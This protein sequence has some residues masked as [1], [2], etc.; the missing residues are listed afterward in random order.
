MLCSRASQGRHPSP[1]AEGREL[2][3]DYD[4]EVKE[5]SLSPLAE[6]RELKWQRDRD[7]Q[8]CRLSPLAEGREL[9]WPLCRSRPR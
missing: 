2:K 1:L 7:T 9:K 6:G 3:L 4:A 8:P 5:I